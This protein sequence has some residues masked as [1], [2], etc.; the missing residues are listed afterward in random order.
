MGKNIFIFMLML[1]W[2][3][4]MS[5][6]MRLPSVPHHY[7]VIAHRG[8]HVEVPEN[9]L[10]A[11]EEAILCGADYVEI[12]VRATRDG[13]LVSVHDETI[14]K[15]TGIPERVEDLTWEEIRSKKVIPVHESDTAEYRIPDFASVLELCRSRIRIYLDFKKA[16]VGQTYQM[17]QEAGMEDQIVVYVNSIE[18]YFEWRSIA[19][20]MPLMA[21]LPGNM[22][23]E[24]LEKW[25]DR[26][27]IAVVDNA[28]DAGEVRWLNE[29]GIAVWLDV[30]GKDEGPQKWN[31]AMEFGVQGMQSD[32]P[33]AL[34][35]YLEQKGIR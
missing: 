15:M 32:Q 27:P 3:H 35:G 28:R 34:V 19:P 10:A 1:V 20:K 31:Q 12:D 25:L 6:E 2:Q 22:S 21:S 5:Q 18:Q 4:G 9:T 11:Y 29:R 30:Q 24:D 26:H 7:V 14:E 23:R 13:H 16:D 33:A 8:N 17:I